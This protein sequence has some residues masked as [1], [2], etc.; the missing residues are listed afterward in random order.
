LEMVRNLTIGAEYFV[1]QND[2]YLTANKERY[3]VSGLSIFGRYIFNPDVF[4]LFARFDRYEPNNKVSSDEMSMVIAG[5]DWAP[6]HKSMKLQPNIWF[7]SYG[8]SAKKNDV[9]FN[10]TFFMSF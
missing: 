1:Y 6:F 7:T 3:D 8:D 5:L 10:L 4:S 9:V 2:K